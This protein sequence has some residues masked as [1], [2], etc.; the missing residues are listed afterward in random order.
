M[1]CW[2]YKNCGREANGSKVDELGIC[3]AYTQNAGT[4][5][6]I[7]AGTFCEGEVQGTFAKKEASCM[8]CSFYMTFDSQ[9]RKKVKDHFTSK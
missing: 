5:C 7:V 6:W 2:E 4:A 1:N 9:L 8:L 3:P